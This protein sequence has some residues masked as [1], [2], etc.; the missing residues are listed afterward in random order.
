MHGSDQEGVAFAHVLA[1]DHAVDNV[2]ANAGVANLHAVKPPSPQAETGDGTPKTPPASSG[3]H[4]FPRGLPLDALDVL[5]KDQVLDVQIEADTVGVLDDGEVEDP[6]PAQPHL[7]EE[8]PE[9]LVFG[10]QRLT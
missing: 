5:P 6:T 7:N 9:P 8:E 2:A 10:P 1:T 4:A 3:P